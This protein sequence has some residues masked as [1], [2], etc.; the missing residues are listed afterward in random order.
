MAEDLN[1]IPGLGPGMIKMLKVHNITTIEQLAVRFLLCR[2]EVTFIVWLF[3]IGGGCSCQRKQCAQWMNVRF[4]GNLKDSKCTNIRRAV[5][6]YLMLGLGDS[7]TFIEWLEDAERRRQMN[8][9]DGHRK[10]YITGRE[11]LSDQSDR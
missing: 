3:A 7:V 1:T 9:N 8:E 4:G 10:E 5:W 11:K 6:R 2:H